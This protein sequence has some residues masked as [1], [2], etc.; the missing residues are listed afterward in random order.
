MY[1][2]ID[3]CSI[4][5]VFTFTV[6]IRVQAVMWWQ[7]SLAAMLLPL[8]WGRDWATAT[9]GDLARPACCI[10]LAWHGLVVR[11]G[12]RL[13]SRVPLV[14]FGGGLAEAGSPTAVC[15]GG[16]WLGVSVAVPTSSTWWH[17]AHRHLAATWHG[18]GLHLL[19]PR[20]PP[21]CYTLCSQFATGS[22]IDTIYDFHGKNEYLLYLD[23]MYVCMKNLKCFYILDVLNHVQIVSCFLMQWLMILR[24]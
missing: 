9:T 19:L 3:I 21:H 11:P 1:K 20:S 13:Y 22:W 16:R 2:Y 24:K 6:D 8:S 14:G 23:Y 18:P 17:W 10:D 12:P 15:V 7:R 4:P 5:N